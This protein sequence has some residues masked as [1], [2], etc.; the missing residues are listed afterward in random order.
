M[1]GHF[2]YDENINYSVF[3][4]GNGTDE[5]FITAASSVNSSF[6]GELTGLYK[7]FISLFIN[8]GLCPENIVFLRFYTD[9]ISSGKDGILNSLFGSLFTEC[10]VSVIQQA[11][12]FGGGISLFAY[13]IIRKS[14]ALQK[15]K[16]NYNA[17][18]NSISVKGKNYELFWTA[19]FY[20]AA[21]PNVYQQTTQVFQ[22][23]TETLGQKNMTLLDN[24]LRT[25]IYVDDID[26]NYSAMTDARKKYFLE[27][28]LNSKTRYIASTGINGKPLK[29][30]SLVMMDAL[31]IGGLTK[32]Q[33]IRMEAPNHLCP[34]INYGVTFERGTRVRYGDRSHLLI[35]GTASIDKNG[36]TLYKGD[37]AK[38]TLQTLENIKAL[39][40][41]QNAGFGDLAYFIVYL[42]NKSDK[43]IVRKII[44]DET[45]NALPV[46]FVEGAV[47]RPD[48]LVE[49]EGIAIIEDRNGF[50]EF[51]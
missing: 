6:S 21:S 36:N 43:D 34:T 26:S 33:L 35:S 1:L 2:R 49:I 19:N 51:L 29:E 48:W 31:S 9:D 40:H 50:G 42:R 10:A 17:W 14:D 25:W 12:L 32:E 28:G 8:T 11:P 41:G 46:L 3:S 45:E 44:S 13:C 37:I 4:S 20:S 47:C 39:L 7:S 38:Q 23:L 30:N 16:Q 27:Q 15:E 24:T 5:Y 22:T 18:Q